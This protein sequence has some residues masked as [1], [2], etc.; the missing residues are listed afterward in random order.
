MGIATYQAVPEKHNQGYSFIQAA[1][2]K[3]I[4]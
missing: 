3:C 1:D 2:I 4:L